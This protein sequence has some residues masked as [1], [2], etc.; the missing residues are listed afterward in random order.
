MTDDEEIIIGVAKKSVKLSGFNIEEE[1]IWGYLCLA[2]KKIGPQPESTESLKDYGPYCKVGDQ[3]GT[4]IQIN[5]K[6][7]CSLSFYVNGKFAGKAFK[8]I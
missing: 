3:V 2:A 6:N 8:D 4:L 5:A 7:K 1:P